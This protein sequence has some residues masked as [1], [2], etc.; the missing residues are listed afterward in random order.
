MA[1]KNLTEAQVRELLTE[2]RTS[3]IR[4]FKSK[5]GNAFD[6]RIMLNKEENGKITGLKFDFHDIAPQ[7]LPRPGLGVQPSASGLRGTVSVSESSLVSA[8]C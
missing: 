2:G 8:S 4:G 7:A 6:A 1:G 5:T 3:T